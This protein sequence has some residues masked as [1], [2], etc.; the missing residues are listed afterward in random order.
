MFSA[1]LL[2]CTSVI[3]QN[4]GGLQ[5]QEESSQSPTQLT[6]QLQVSEKHHH[7]SVA[8]EI[9]TQCCTNSASNRLN[10]N[11]ANENVQQIGQGGSINSNRF[12]TVVNESTTNVPLYRITGRRITIRIKEP[13]SEQTDVLAWL[14]SAVRG[15]HHYLISLCN[16]ENDRI[17]VTIQSDHFSHGMGWISFRPVDNF[18]EDDLWT[19]IEGL[20]QSNEHFHID[21]SFVLQATYVSIPIGSG[22]SRK[23][24]KITIDTIA[25]RS[26][27]NINNSDDNLCLPRSLVVGEYYIKL[28]KD[29]SDEKKKIWKSLRNSSRQLQKRYAEK[30]TR[31]AGVVIPEN[32]C[33]YAEIK[34]FQSFYARA[35]TAIVVYDKFDMG[36]GEE[37]FFDG[38][39]K[40]NGD[41]SGV[42][43]LCYDPDTH[44]FDTII[45]LTGAVG[46]AFF[47][48]HC[49]K[50]YKY[51][52]QHVCKYTC[53]SCF[54]TPPCATDV[55]MIDC[56]DCNR[57]FFGH[58][59]FRKHKE[60]K[61]HKNQKLCDVLKR[62][63]I[64]MKLMNKWSSC[65][66]ICGVNYCNT[67]KIK[68]ST[69]EPCYMQPIS[70]IVNLSKKKPDLFLFYDFECR[71]EDAYQNNLTE[72]IHVPNLCVVQQVCTICVELE[73]T[74]QFCHV[75]GIREY[76][77]DREPVKQLID[78][79]CRKNTAF[80]N[81]VCLAHNGGAYD[82]QFLL[83][84]IVD[85]FSNFSPIVILKGQRLI[86]LQI[87]RTKFIDSI[88]FFHMKLAALP[89]AFGFSTTKGYFPHLFNVKANENY[90]GEMPDASFYSPDTMS[91]KEKDNF[92]E[93]Y[94][95]QIDRNYKFNFKEE[96]VKYCRL[97]VEI[98]RQAC[99]KFRKLFLDVGK[100]DPFTEA[101]TIASACSVVFRKNY[102]KPYTIG[103]I[104][105]NGYL[106][107]DKQSQ[108]AIEWLLQCER[109]VG[110]EIIHAGRWRE[111]RLPDAGFK[112]DGYLPPEEDFPDVV[113][114][115]YSDGAKGTVYEFYGCYYHGCTKCFKNNRSEPRVFNSSF[116]EVY[117]NT[118][119]RIATIKGFGY[120]VREIWECEFDKI[121]FENSEI[122]NFVENHPLKSKTT[123]NPRDAFY[124][125]RTENFSTMHEIE[126]GEKIFYT[127]ICSLYPYICKKGKFPLKHPK[128]YVGSLCES[129]TNGNN[130]D[131]ST[132][133]GLIKC[134][135]LPPRNLHLPVLPVKMHG[136][137]L[138]PLCRSCCEEVRKNY[139]NHE[140]EE[141]REFTGTWVSDEL[142]K[143]IHLGYKIKKIFVI[144]QYKMTCYDQKTQKGGLFAGYINTFLKLK[145]QA[146]GWPE[147][148]VDED[149]KIKYLKEYE[150]A[151]GI[152]L[153]RDKIEKNPGLRSLSKMMLNTLW[154]KFGQ[155][156]KLKQT[157]I[158]KTREELLDL[159]TTPEKEV[160]SILVANERVLFVNWEYRDEAVQSAPHAS[161]VIACYV[162]CQARLKLYEY[163]EKLQNQIIYVDTDSTIFKVRENALNDY[164]VPI[165]MFLGDM[166]DELESYGQNSFIKTFV[167]TGPKSYAAQI[168][169]G[170][171]HEV[172]EICKVKGI[173]L[174]F[175]NS[176][177]INFTSLKNLVSNI[178]TEKNDDDANYDK[179]ELQFR[180]IRRLPGHVIVTRDETKTCKVVLEKRV[181]LNHNYSI[182][183]GFA[184]PENL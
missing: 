157:T 123:L 50:Q 111:Y 146:S 12:F 44:H 24:K 83:K 159:M 152:K 25:Q 58:T 141:D 121:K 2:A 62:C 82:N 13:T 120:I 143:S 180:S 102:L 21:E 182:P 75:C 23:K 116:D 33:G 69:H 91:A 41:I 17:G 160:V 95:E 155:A 174:N 101:T 63:N 36:S 5:R 64:C 179:I 60:D 139:C 134:T 100:T 119:S 140:R 164:R 49:N 16:D 156:S 142:K 148:C 67:C 19:L 129:L 93:W 137:L 14:E 68:H 175:L 79:S 115:S 65:K 76:I 114:G 71:Q 86:L 88:N 98:L 184:K 45:N 177:K 153:D 3:S 80:G 118:L 20:T 72:K 31:K 61:S 30:L 22:P 169:S 117:E 8:Q 37:P 54:F 40:I 106:R 158:V 56:T 43:Y 42:I 47:C 103:L 135:V 1:I 92:F 130:N 29:E 74:T 10:N 176:K 77:F 90:V 34:K 55:E 9:T 38:R 132:V 84:T 105:P 113:S 99:L 32:G 162:T 15:V 165:G 96:I 183:F 173:T 81:I 70:K 161:V 170:K 147:W 128:I 11:N 39:P 172:S 85:K 53:A 154:G 108:K 57:K 168:V 46:K 104:P 6:A 126:E 87:G 59:C 181:F 163:L 89:S 4:T 52:E 110:R 51:V 73:D 48:S 18:L 144:W 94:N 97:D 109:E 166:T 107:V 171:T 151:E 125:G 27:V 178:F 122:R 150:Q 131:L 133:E 26:F 136:R 167:C 127:D 78:L 112:V 7:T 35:N 124:G 145:Q 28:K 66:H 149:S 138:F